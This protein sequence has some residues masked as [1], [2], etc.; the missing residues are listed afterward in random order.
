MLKETLRGTVIASAVAGLFA[1]NAGCK[2]EAKMQKEGAGAMVK[3]AG[4]NECRGKGACNG[5]KNSCSGQNA[6][7]GQGWIEVHEKECKDKGGTVT[8]QR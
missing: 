1:V 6:C 7:K 5:A 4:I 8:V 3:C 2:Q